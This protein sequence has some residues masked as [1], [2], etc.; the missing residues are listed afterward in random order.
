MDDVIQMMAKDLLLPIKEVE[1]AIAYSGSRTRR[2]E[3][4][5]KSGGVRVI[6]QPSV[7][8]KPILSWLDAA[9]LSKLPVHG[10][11]TA[12]RQDK[13]ILENATVHSKSKY[14]VRV[15]ISKFFPSIR[16]TDVERAINEAASVLPSWGSS[17][18]TTTLISKICFDRDGTLPIGY[19][20]SPAIANAVMY[21]LDC[22]LVE[23]ISRQVDFGNA[24]VTRYA[25]DYVFST[26]KDGACNTFVAALANMLVT[27]TSPKLSINQAKTR[28][29]SKAGGSTLITG[30]R[31]NNQGNVVVHANYRDH[32]RLLLKLFKS[33]RLRDDDVPKLVGHLAYV[34]HVDPAFFTKLSFRFHE[35]IHSLRYGGKS[36][37]E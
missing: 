18:S 31:I 25:D 16:G 28:Y 26:D 15:D 1:K 37:K 21:K 10:I 32:V 2:F 29:M 23:K 11:A 19:S 33:Q 5:K 3:I 27:C 14:S 17:P 13:S 24:V 8:L 9:L 22:E 34:Q 12:F 6:V 30:L 7:K 36:Q 20:T 4:P 35:E